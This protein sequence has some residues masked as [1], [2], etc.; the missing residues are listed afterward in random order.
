MVISIQQFVLNNILFFKE[1]CLYF[2]SP[3]SHS[4]LL[5]LLYICLM[6]TATVDAAICSCTIFRTDG[7]LGSG[8]RIETAAPSLNACRCFIV[9]G[10]I[11]G[12][13]CNA[14]IVSCT[15][16]NNIYCKVPDTSKPSCLLAA[17]SN[18][19]GY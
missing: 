13:R 16:P 12:K 9:Q 4:L 19:N 11:G 8:C 1:D 17:N 10:A 6:K 14:E 5:A 15:D 3:I 2:Q 7:S 18:C